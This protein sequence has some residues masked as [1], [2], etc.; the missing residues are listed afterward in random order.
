M[1]TDP[2][3]GTFD[4]LAPTADDVIEADEATWRELLIVPEPDFVSPQLIG[5]GNEV[6]VELV[7]GSASAP[8]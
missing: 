2:Q 7:G 6:L 5:G 3:E 1:N 8:R 4:P